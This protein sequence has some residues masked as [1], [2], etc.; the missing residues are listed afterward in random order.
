M[1]NSYRQIVSVSLIA[2]INAI[3]CSLATWENLFH[4]LFS[5]E[6]N[7]GVAHHNG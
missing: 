6:F 4:I 5:E 1:T 2:R 3:I 7:M